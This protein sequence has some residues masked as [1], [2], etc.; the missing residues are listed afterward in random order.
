MKF[1]VLA[2]GST[3]N[4]TYIETAH[5]KILIDIGMSCLYVENNLK[6][7][8]V[9]PDTIKA[10]IITHIHADHIGGLKVFVKKHKPIVYLTEKM[11]EELKEY[12]YEYVIID[13]KFSFDDITI[14]PFS[15]SHDAP[16]TNGY[17][18]ENNNKSLVYITDTGYLNQKY[19]QM[20]KNRNIYIMESNHDVKML[21][22]G[23]YQYHLKQ[24][25]LSDKGHL[26]NPDSTYYLSKMIG[27]NTKYIVQAH[28]SKEN[29]TEEIAHET[30]IKMLEDYSY[31]IE[32]F[33]AKPNIRMELK[34][35]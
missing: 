15:L 16:E 4:V 12:L 3:G 19:F 31:D 5:T 14:T 29:N 18:V 1:S 8:D 23:K 13:D 28:L 34:E 10:I 9:D 33:V 27:S 25:I 22:E 26:S 6:E 35:V 17:L 24:R 32:T 30:L 7:M 2:S 11:Y 20:L 21:M